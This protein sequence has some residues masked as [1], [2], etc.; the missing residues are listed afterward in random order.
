MVTLLALAVLPC[1]AFELERAEML[2]DIA[3]Q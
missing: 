3:T 2:S 1:F